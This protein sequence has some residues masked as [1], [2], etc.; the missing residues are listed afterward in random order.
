M[1]LASETGWIGNGGK[2]RR[3]DVLR[4]GA[5]LGLSGA[6]LPAMARVRKPLGVVEITLTKALS[7]DYAGTLKQVAA[8]GYSHFG[9]RMAAGGAGANQPSSADK[10]RMARDAGLQVGLARFGV[11]PQS[12]ERDIADA[13]AIGATG[14][15]MSAAP[16]FASARG[17]GVASRADFDAWL[18]DLAGLIARCRAAG[19]TFVYHNHWWDVMPLDGG[20]TPLDILARRFSPADLAFEVDLAWAWYGGVAPLDLLAR[21]GPRVVSM[22]LKDIDRSK[23]R[24]GAGAAAT[25]QQAVVIGQGEMGYDRLLP[26]IGRITRA[27][28]YIEIDAPADGLIAAAQGAR[29][30][31][32][33]G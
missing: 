26:R 24:P 25:G 27:V 5:A 16:V 22:H 17:L 18:T 3:R 9:F 14:I 4:A 8:M 2:A 31:R 6:A 13:A 12:Q 28:G 23:A 19:L 10:A 21:L 7:R 15:V 30:F 32:E 29:F 33:Y 11:T 20:E 1:G